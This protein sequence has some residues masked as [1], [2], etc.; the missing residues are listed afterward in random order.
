MEPQLQGKVVIVT[1]AA[2]G[3]GRA[4]SILFARNGSSVIVSDSD[5]EGGKGTVEEI[6]KEGGRAF[7]VKTD[8]SVASNTTARNTQFT[9]QD[10]RTYAFRTIARDRAGNVEV[11]PATNDT[12]TIVDHT[13]PF[14]TS[15]NALSSNSTPWIVV[16]FSEPM[17]RTSVEQAFNVTPMVSGQFRWSADSRVVTFVPSGPLPAASYF[18]LV[19]T[20]NV[21]ERPYSA[22][23]TKTTLVSIPA[24]ER[25]K[26]GYNLQLRPDYS[27]VSKYWTQFMS[28]VAAT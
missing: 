21:F 28:D 17:N 22:F 14:I 5:V 27:S 16:T 4:S 19:D 15:A 20:I 18:A 10:G 6:T 2:S 9:G 25:S 8:V 26:H 13:P 1:G 12:W 7:F 11:A 3:I 24:A 23:D